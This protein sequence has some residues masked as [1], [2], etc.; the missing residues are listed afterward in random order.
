[1]I[2]AGDQWIQLPTKD[3]YDTQMM[4]I[5][6]NAAKDMYEKGQQEMKDFKKEYGDFLTPITAD[7]D[8]YNQ[9]VTGKVRDVVNAL[10]AQGIDPLRNAQGRA[11]IAQTINNMP[12]GDIAKLRTSAA[13]AQ[14]FLKAKQKLQAEG[15]WN[16]MLDPYDGPSLSNYSTLKSGIWDRVSPTPYENMADFSKSYF[17][18]IS[19]IQ[20]SAT[21]NGISYT[22]S[23][24]TEPMLYD[25]ADR[26]FNDLVSTPQGQMMYKFYKDKL[27]SDEAARKAFNDAVVSGNLDRRKYADDYEARKDHAEN[28]AMKKRELSLR[29]QDLAL[30]RQNA[31]MRQRLMEAKLGGKD[32]ASKWT[33]RQRVNIMINNKDKADLRLDLAKAK[34]GTKPYGAKLQLISEGILKPTQAQIDA[35]IKENQNLL[36]TN[37]EM[38]A[39]YY[40]TYTTNV[41]GNDLLTTRALFAGLTKEEAVADIEGIKRAHVQF[42]PRENLTLTRIRQHK[43][44]GVTLK[45][46]RL[47]EYLDKNHVSGYVPYGL[48]TVSYKDYAPGASVFDINSTVRIKAGDLN[49]FRKKDADRLNELARNGA[50]FVDRQ[51]KILS[52]EGKILWSDIQYVDLPISRTIDSKGYVDSEIDTYHETLNYTKKIAK[53]QQGGFE[54][55]DLN[56][57]LYD[58]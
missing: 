20:R 12:I 55:D 27:G 36:D 38:Y 37:G 9:N 48:P 23:E 29:E 49:G 22:V 3:L 32:G 50:V 15:K 16:A 30:K 11:I 43:Y 31:A 47:Q 24:I 39:K 2:Y 53:D 57:M 4:A 56:N 5:A 6:I 1:M 14:E 17:D 7:Q 19:P 51:G 13:N 18:N 10:Y 21:K 58:E 45:H 41:E 25:I 54:Q 26:H 33:D 44:A 40:E 28:L 8:W 35:K 34:V 42:G 46:N 52:K